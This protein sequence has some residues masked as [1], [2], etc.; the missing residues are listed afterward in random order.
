MTTCCL[1]LRWLNASEWLKARTN[2]PAVALVFPEIFEPIRRQRRVA[3]RRLDG[4]MP[5]VSLDR[6][7]ILTICRQLEP[8]AVAQHVAMDQK[9]KPGSLASTGKGTLAMAASC[10]ME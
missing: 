7:G 3:H 1:E 4:A 6:A 5:E 8:A 9:T 2:V 10:A